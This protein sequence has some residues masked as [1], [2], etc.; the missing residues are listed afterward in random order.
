MS[1]RARWR[2]WVDRGGTFT[3]C[4]GQDPSTGALRVTKVLSS[5]EAPLLGIR[6]L[7]G[8]RPH[9]PIPP[10]ELRMGT[11]LGTNALLERQGRPCALAIT[12]GF[13]DLLEIGDQ[14]RP[15]IFAV[16]IHRPPPLHAG[17]LELDARLDPDGRVLARPE[18][19]AVRRELRRLRAD[20]LRSLA[21]VVM[22]AYRDG[23][24][25]Q[26][27]ARIARAEGFEHVSCSHEVA[28]E[29]GLLAR[30]DTTVVDAY[31]TPLLQDYLDGLRQALPGSD[32]RVMGSSGGLHPAD[33]FR[34]RDAVLSGPAG[35]VVACA[36][37][38]RTHGLPAILGLD[39]GGTST[40]VCRVGEAL[41]RVYE[42]RVA[43]VRLRTPMLAIHTVAAGGGSIC[44][45][46]HGRLQVG[47]HSAGADPGPLCYGRPHASEPTLT[48]VDLLLGRLCDDRFP[49]PLDPEP[50]RRALTALRERLPSPW[51]ERPLAAVAQGF[52]EVAVEH[53]VEAL[54]RVTTA[55]GHDARDHALV[56]FG[57][58]GGQ[59]ACALARRLGVAQLLF[60]PL[61]GALSALGMGLAPLLW[62][63][64]VDLGRVPLTTDVVDHAYGQSVRLLH[65]G[66]RALGDDGIPGTHQQGS[67]RVEL[68]Y[69]GTETALAIE[70]P[71]RLETDPDPVTTLRAAFEAEHRRELGYVR[72]GHPLEAVTL[73]VELHGTVDAPA[74]P[75]APAEPS[76][77]PP[78]R[79][80]ALWID[81]RFVDAPVYAR[82]ALP[83]GPT[84]TGPALV[85][86]DTGTLV[87]EPG[88]TLDVAHDGSLRLKDVAGAPRPALGT[89]CDPVQLEIFAH[90]FMSIAE[91]MGTVLRR[92]ALSTNIRERLD[93]SCAVFDREGSLV[94]NAPHL[95]VH[96]GAMGESVAA[97]AA[98]H[99][100]PSPGD[101]F[102]TNDPTAGGS[103]LPDITVVTPVHVEGALA[104]W[105]AS[106]GHHADVGGITPGSMPPNSRRLDEEGVVFR[107]QRIVDGGTLDTP[108]ILATLGTGPHPARR[109][110]ENLADL[111]A[112][113]AANHAGVRLLEALVH[114]H[115]RPVVAAYMQHVQDNAARA[116][117][118]AIARL[119]DGESRFVDHTDDGTPIAVTVRIAGDRAAIDFTGTGPAVDGN[120]NA[121]RAITVAAVLYVLRCLVGEPIP[122]NRGCLEPVTLTIPPGSLLDPAPHHAVA[123]G[124][125]ETAQRLCDVLLAAMGIQAA[126]QG[127]MNNLT[128]GDATF[129]YYE[130]IGGG[131]GASPEHDGVSGV[132]THMTNTRITDP[133]VLEARFPVRLLEFSLRRGS[134]GAG[135]RRGGDGLVR[136]LRLL[137][138]LR[139]SILS[140]RRRA[141]PF[142]LAGGSP[143]S[144]GRNVVH[145]GDRDALELPG[146]ATVDVIAGDIV[147][148]ETPGGGGHG[149]AEHAPQRPA[150][151]QNAPAD[152]SPGT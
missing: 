83:R 74:L 66:R 119:P 97:I 73:R 38:A 121:P 124:N 10:C 57:G 43:G 140:D 33:R 130:T 112:Q 28:P 11:T 24:L 34:G 96:L 106:R 22:H 86:D 102:A 88:W 70:L 149:A 30:G 49:F 27:L 67:L 111:Q 42:T 110:A 150:T 78:L 65:R 139:V 26:E 25:E 131:E 133:E 61:P 134:G 46:E 90:R 108:G 56:V 123:G 92:T 48:D 71:P 7:L 129:G 81:G 62:H 29:I 144:A 151:G 69:A 137:A 32:V 23:T 132:H 114:E 44:R 125:V 6:A 143:G 135:H 40:D 95:P 109:P 2:F 104:F 142:G 31:L 54:R 84:L 118:E 100:E 136:R 75:T 14:S 55:R 47:P 45:F 79:R 127:T 85:L 117:A 76:L 36:A 113:I 21:I 128:F 98:Q 91:Q 103:H 152:P 15:E 147:S 82:D 116:V 53:T 20:G 148:I 94:A 107:G 51:R 1:T 115:G 120:L 37:L 64:E 4:I 41:P 9:D 8:L 89:A 58:A 18:L 93:F 63:G 87:L 13:G 17:V 145:T 146:R 39:V 105:V 99:P 5:D 126:S 141:P 59:L 52:F 16:P 80:T 50:A 122:L 12:A 72:D 138:P 101:V 35:G 3:D 68:R 19:D 77:P 60:P